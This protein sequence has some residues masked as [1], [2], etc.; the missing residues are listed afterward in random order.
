MRPAPLAALAAVLLAPAVHAQ[1]GNLDSTFGA[2]G[3]VVYS[4]GM[5]P[6]TV[7]GV[8]VT[9]AGIFLTG[10]LEYY[11]GNFDFLVHRLGPTGTYLANSGPLAFD[12][13]ASGSDFPYSLA[14][15]PGG[16]L[17]V[18]GTAVDPSGAHEIGVARLDQATLGL[19]PGF[20][21]SGKVVLAFGGLDFNN[22]RLAV[23]GD[24]S[25][26]VGV[27]FGSTISTDT[28]FGVFKLLPDGSPDLAFGAF[29]FAS[30]AFDLGGGHADVLGGLAVQ[31][32]G[33]I[34]LAGSAEWTA[35]DLDFALA[36]LDATGNPDTAFGPY[37]TGKT[38][39]P[40]DLDA[41]ATDQA[42]AVALAADGRIAAV[43]TAS[44]GV[45]VGA[46]AMLTPAGELDSAFDG[47]GRQFVQW[48]GGGTAVNRPQAAAFESD[49]SLFVGG[50]AYWNYGGDGLLGIARLLPS[51]AFDPTF[52]GGGFYSWNL[53]PG[54][55][56][57]EAAALDG[58]RPV[59]VGTRNGAWATV[60]LTN[61][62]IFRDG[63]ESG[64]THAWSAF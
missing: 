27:T 41:A 17:V 49:G 13:V 34:V 12:L 37:G 33:K 61:A 35:P 2:G 6:S 55:E 36:R 47:D 14:A 63:F 25:V 53:D 30:V 24:G 21:G 45:V 29:G 48:L 54:W 20:N 56:T 1:D 4:V 40:F 43:G 11:A 60:R 9:E 10:E 5:S 7:R 64:S 32:D 3:Q 57:V 59:L 52:F 23:L 46:V 39:V 44:N 26:L 31:P 51:G 19:D 58:G 62:L 28:D 22:P 42:L 8:A 18:A 15:A 16:K 38:F 50:D